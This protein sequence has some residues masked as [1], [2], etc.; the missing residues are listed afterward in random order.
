MDAKPD[1]SHRH[2]HTGL[3]VGFVKQELRIELVQFW[4]D[5]STLCVQVNVKI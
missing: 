3:F 5:E 4:A 2:C 1:L